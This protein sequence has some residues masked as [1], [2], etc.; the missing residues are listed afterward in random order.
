[1]FLSHRSTALASIAASLAAVALLFAPL[2]ASAGTLKVGSMTV[3][4]L[5]V[6]NLKCNIK[7]G[8]FMAAMVV[9][10]GLAKQKK[11]LQACS[12]GKQR[13]QAIWHYAGGKIT[14]AKVSTA[15]SAATKAC[16]AKAL[17]KVKS[18]NLAG[19]CSAGIVIG[20]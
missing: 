5:K 1:M 9:V 12:K 3:N 8:G 6:V 20:K 11:A 7:G 15:N 19:I 16:V 10:S 13:V 14:G 17:S 2:T 4:G 18:G